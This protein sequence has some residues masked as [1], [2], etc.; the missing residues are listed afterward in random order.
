M[1]FAPADT[2]EVETCN[3]PLRTKQSGFENMKESCRKAD[4]NPETLLISETLIALKL[5][6]G[7][8]LQQLTYFSLGILR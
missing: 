2:A 3:E 7:W 4:Q 1:L 6:K 8:P 5:L